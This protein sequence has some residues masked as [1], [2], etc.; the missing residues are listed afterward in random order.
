MFLTL[1]INVLLCKNKQNSIKYLLFGFIGDRFIRTSQGWKN[2]SIKG[3]SVLCHV[4]QPLEVMI[5]P[6]FKC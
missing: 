2:K 1:F 4:A 3:M 5:I 6:F